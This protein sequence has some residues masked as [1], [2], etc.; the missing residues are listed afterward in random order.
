[1]FW[2]QV[3]D[4]LICNGLHQTMKKN[5]AELPHSPLHK[6]LLKIRL[7]M[8]EIPRFLGLYCFKTRMYIHNGSKTHLFSSL[9]QN[10]LKVEGQ[11][12][13]IQVFKAFPFISYVFGTL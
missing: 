10:K 5:L 9:E 11:N 7:T 12:R 3:F 2:R 8:E 1:M 6:N 4:L 13:R